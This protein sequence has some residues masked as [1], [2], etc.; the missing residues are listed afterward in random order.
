M[1]TSATVQEPKAH[2]ERLTGV[3]FTSIDSDLDGSLQ[4]RRKFWMV[5]ADEHYYET[6]RKLALALAD[7]GLTVLAFCPSRVCAERMVARLPKSERGEN[8]QVRVYRA[9]LSPKEREEIEQGL[10]DRSVRVVFSTSALE[11]GIDIGEIDVVLCVGLPNSMMSLW[12]RAGRTA[13]AGR[14][15]AAILIPADTPIDTYYAG[16]PDEFFGRD[17][18][19]LV[20][21]LSNRR[22]VCQHYAC[23][24]QE[25][26]GDEN[27]LNLEVLGREIACVQQL[28]AEGK[29]QS[30]RV[31]SFGPTYR[32]QYSRYRRGRLFADVWRRQNRRN[33]RLSPVA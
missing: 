16:H 9:G 25:A 13:R 23:A 26:G 10:R 19:P 21:N 15:G 6:G 14:E 30:R 33:R 8:S 11:L 4:G 2:M 29:A 7:A 3:E 27:R 1:A 22:I 31:L 20:L 17:H 5:G 32:N 18:E 28:R 24:V 12:Q